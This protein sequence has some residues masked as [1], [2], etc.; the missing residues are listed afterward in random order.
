M[1]S[2]DIA[3][4]ADQKFSTIL[5]NRRVTFRLRFNYTSGRWSMDLALDGDY[6]LHGRRIVPNVDLIDPFAFGIGVIFAHSLNGHNPG[7]QELVDGR[8]KIY[9]ASEAEKNVATMA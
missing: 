4:A 1:I 7:R 2:F 9:Q 5:N 8:V 6:V 3:D